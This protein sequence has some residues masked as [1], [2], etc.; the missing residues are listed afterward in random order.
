MLRGI[1]II[2]KKCYSYTI[3]LTTLNSNNYYNF[4]EQRKGVMSGRVTLIK[5]LKTKNK[6][7]EGKS[8]KEN[9]IVAYVCGTCGGSVSELC[10]CQ[11]PV[12]D[13]EI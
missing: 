2:S 7:K 4:L 13:I 5:K 12:G 1:D 3:D 11:K 10:R 9:I 6:N 8:E